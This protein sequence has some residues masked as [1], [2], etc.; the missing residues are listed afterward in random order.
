M[1]ILHAS[2]FLADGLR[3]KSLEPSPYN[4]LKQHRVTAA[5]FITNSFV[6]ARPYQHPRVAFCTPESDYETPEKIWQREQRKAASFQRSESA[7]VSRKSYHYLNRSSSN[8]ARAHSDK[9]VTPKASP[10]APEDSM[11]KA[12]FFGVRRRLTGLTAP[13]RVKLLA[14]T[15]QRKRIQP[16]NIE[17]GDSESDDDSDVKVETKPTT[18]AEIVLKRSGVRYYYLSTF[19]YFIALFSLV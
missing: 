15:C 11:P 3:S 9:D 19:T 2:L 1:F 8:G 17:D 13:V 6:R 10:G 7:R 14:P 4:T 5:P 12:S 16:M 18:L